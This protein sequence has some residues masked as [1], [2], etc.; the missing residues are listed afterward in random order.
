LFKWAYI[1][2]EHDD[3]QHLFTIEVMGV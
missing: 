1:L 3:L 2:F